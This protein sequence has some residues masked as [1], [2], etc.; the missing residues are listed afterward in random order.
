MY[1]LVF[2]YPD[3]H[4]APRSYYGARR[5]IDRASTHNQLELDTIRGS[6][7]SRWTVTGFGNTAFQKSIWDVE[8]RINLAPPNG[9]LYTHMCG[10]I[11]TVETPADAMWFRLNHENVSKNGC[12]LIEMY[13]DLD[14]KEIERL[15]AEFD[16]H[17]TESCN[18]N[19]IQSALG[20]VVWQLNRITTTQDKN[21]NPVAS[22]KFLS[23]HDDF[24]EERTEVK[25]RMEACM[26]NMKSTAQTL[27]DYIKAHRT[28][29]N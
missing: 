19:S 7:K 11:I 12:R 27:F 5:R 25:E 28:E 24:Y 10:H 8:S 2:H 21:G 22:K 20:Q 26:K 23:L 4:L 15:Y 1:H 13:R 9:Y 18:L 3:K 17:Y 6:I 16:V 14:V 29:I